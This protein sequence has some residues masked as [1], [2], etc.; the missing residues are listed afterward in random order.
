VLSGGQLVADHERAWAWHQTITDP[1]HKAA[2][3]ALRRQRV[4]ALRPVREPE[5]EQ[6][7][8]DVYDAMLGTGG[9]GGAA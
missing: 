7:S 1:E 2:A 4:G 5:V 8:L 3:A 6:R 9:D